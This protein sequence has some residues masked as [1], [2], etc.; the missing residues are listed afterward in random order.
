[1]G[2]SLFLPLGESHIYGLVSDDATVHLRDGFSGFFR[3]WETNEAESSAAS[4]RRHHLHTKRCTSQTHRI[5]RSF[6]SLSVEIKTD[7]HLTTGD[8]PVRR[9]LF[10]ENLRV[11]AVA[12][13]LHVQIDALRDV[14]TC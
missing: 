9:E 7:I 10:V 4:S 2:L 3:R 13:I 12:Q 5:K 11:Y 1:M 6:Y 14:Y 8:G